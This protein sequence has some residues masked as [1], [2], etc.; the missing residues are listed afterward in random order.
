MANVI[1]LTSETYVKGLTN[2][3]DNVAAKYLVSSIREAQ[4]IGLTSILGSNLTG[5]LIAK[6]ADGSINTPENAAYKELLDNCQYYIAYKAISELVVKVSYKI[7]NAGVV[8][9]ANE[10]VQNASE[11]EIM[12]QRGYYQS[13]ADYYA[14]L[15]Q[16]FVCANSA[17][18]P[19]LRSSDIYKIKAN[20]RSSATCGIFL[21][22]S[23]GVNR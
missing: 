6:V 16:R 15:L 21:G 4:D 11:G 2:I 8:K 1:L 22:G 13:K 19:E 17:Q 18:F 10:N 9:T 14:N 12:R 7:S 20:L 23:R 3:S 5:A